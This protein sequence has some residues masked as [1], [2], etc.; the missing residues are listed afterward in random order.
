MLAG[1]SEEE[2]SGGGVFGVSLVEDGGVAGRVLCL[3]SGG[4]PVLLAVLD[5]RGRG[6]ARGE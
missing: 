4:V 6:R 2:V 3:T 1:L 5:V